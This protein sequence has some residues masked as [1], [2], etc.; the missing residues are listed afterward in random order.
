VKILLASKSDTARSKSVS[1]QRLVNLYAE[2]NPEGAKYP[3]T[4]YGT[5]GSKE[6][7]DDFS[8][9][10]IQGQQVMGDSMYVVTGNGVNKI[11]SDIVV[12]G[13]GDLSGTVDRVDLANNGTQMVAV[14]PADGT[15]W[16]ITSTTVTQITDPDFPLV[17]S[18]CF[19]DGYF[20]FSRKDTGQFII[21]T[22]YD[23]TS[24]DALDFATAEEVPDNLVRVT[25]FNGGLWL[26]GTD[27]YEFYANTGNAD[28]PYEQIGGAGNTSRGLAA[29]FA[30]AQEDNSLFFLGNDRVVY[31][32]VGYTPQRISTHAVETAISGYSVIDDAFMFTYT[33]DGHKF[34][35][36]TFP[37]ANATW[38]YDIA[39]DLWHER[40]STNA[41]SVYSPTTGTGRW[42]ANAYA[43]FAGK[44]LIGDFSNGKI[45]ELDANTFD[46]D[47]K[48]I[49]RI[50]QGS[51]QWA[52]GDRV[53]H[54]RVRL[55]LDAG[56]GIDYRLLVVKPLVANAAQGATLVQVA[57]FANLD[58]SG[59]INIELDDGT[60]FRT[61]VSGTIDN[62]VDFYIAIDDA[63]PSAA[64]SGNNAFCYAYNAPQ[65]AGLEREPQVMM[66][67]S[68]DGGIT[69]SNERWQGMGDLGERKTQVQ[70]RRNGT[71]RERIYQFKITD[72][73]KV[74]ITGAYV[75]VRKGLT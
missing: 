13:L 55:D 12:T 2:P 61:G 26:P 3:F 71:A 10:G 41:G 46:E 51:V 54:D 18:V 69:F 37:T 70:W 62:G 53:T 49:E 5:H 42:R 14:I 66:K 73:V 39:T 63:L 15:A 50:A 60:T 9:T 11:D 36:L 44:H 19:L 4:L 65:P 30:V 33:I 28:F 32:M 45:Y 27:S 64:A 16:V 7:A 74:V 57:N 48:Y 47:G 23:G 21:S 38:C 58:R 35:T 8:S 68:D 24:Y 34:L 22:L 72:P 1:G 17:T 75:D 20:I 59:W 67:Y 52:D 6:W 56:Q 43:F 25:A 31:R 29:R 40:S